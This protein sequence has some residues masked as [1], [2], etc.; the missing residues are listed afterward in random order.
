MKLLLWACIVSV[1]LARRRRLPFFDEDYNGYYYPLN[2]LNVPDGL[3]NS[4]PPLYYAPVNTIIPNYPGNPNAERGLPPYPWVLTVPKGPYIYNIPG[5]PS[6]TRLTRPFLPRPL[7]GALPFVPPSRIYAPPVAAEPAAAAPVAVVPIA[8]DPAA[9]DPAAAA[10]AAA[11]PAAADPA[12]A[13]PVAAEPAAAAPVATD[14]LAPE[15][16]AV[17]PTIT[18]PDEAE[19]NASRPLPQTSAFS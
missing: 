5:S 13:V 18:E 14:P 16:T 4:Q 11:D 2:P 8:A 17:V 15:L 12:A 6:A 9:A 3:R 19:A 7:P 10:P 1:A